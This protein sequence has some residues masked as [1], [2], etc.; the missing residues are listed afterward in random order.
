AL[1][2]LVGTR[3]VH[4]G[5]CGASM[6]V[7]CFD[8]PCQAFR[9]PHIGYRRVMPPRPEQLTLRTSFAKAIRQIVDFD[10]DGSELGEHTLLY[11]PS[12]ASQIAARREIC[13]HRND[14]R[15]LSGQDEPLDQRRADG[16]NFVLASGLFRPGWK[17]T[18]EVAQEARRMQ[19]M[20]LPCMWEKRNVSFDMR[21]FE[22]RTC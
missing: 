7:R 18:N 4:L 10:A 13:N 8:D 20:L 22:Y 21:Q 15:V 16:D 6:G 19:R 3:G 9:N 17:S 11:Q 14:A 1:K 5:Q 12:T 2:R